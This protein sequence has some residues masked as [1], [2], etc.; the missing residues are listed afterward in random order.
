MDQSSDTCK[1][2]CGTD[3][4]ISSF[5]KNTHVLCTNIFLLASSNIMHTMLWFTHAFDNE[6]R[7]QFI[8]RF[9]IAD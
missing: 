8:K 4:P 5:V 1:C 6:E 9:L 2:I 7:I 3:P